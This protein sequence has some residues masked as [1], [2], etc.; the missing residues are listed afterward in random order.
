MTRYLSLPS[1]TRLRAAVHVGAGLAGFLEERQTVRAA[2]VST[3][4][5]KHHQFGTPGRCAFPEV[6]SV[7][8]GGLATASRLQGQAQAWAVDS[9]SRPP[10]PTCARPRLTDSPIPEQSSF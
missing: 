10:G 6:I 9:G 8:R 4:R 7:A 3:S 1:P 5:A 2:L